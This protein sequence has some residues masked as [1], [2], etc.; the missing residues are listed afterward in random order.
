MSRRKPGLGTV[1]NLSIAWEGMTDSLLCKSCLNQEQ[2]F[3][4]LWVGFLQCLLVNLFFC[5]SRSLSNNLLNIVNKV[6]QI[7]NNILFFCLLLLRLFSLFLFLN[8]LVSHYYSW[9]LPSSPSYLLY[10][11]PQSIMSC[12][13]LCRNRNLLATSLLLLFPVPLIWVPTFFKPSSLASA[14]NTAHFPCQIGCLAG[15]FSCFFLLR[16]SNAGLLNII[17]SV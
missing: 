14:V 5:L 3:S 9:S 12:Q 16:P 11:T 1:L 2:D 4:V 17:F 10:S 6:T 15:S 13:S 8:H 7:I